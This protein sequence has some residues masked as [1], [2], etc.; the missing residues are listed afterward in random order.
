VAAGVAAASV[1]GLAAAAYADALPPALQSIAHAVIGA[2]PAHSGHP[3]GQNSARTSGGSGPAGVAGQA[4][5]VPSTAPSAT[6]SPRP[7]GPSTVAVSPRSGLCTAWREG[8]VAADSVAYQALVKAAGSAE[9][10]PGYCGAPMPHPTGPP[11]AAGSS[12]GSA[13]P[14]QPAHPDW[15]PSPQPTS[16]ARQ[17]GAVGSRPAH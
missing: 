17:A 14:A 8:G 3:P 1:T 13:A 4:G 12:A 9:A 5:G 16:S 2:P 10:I 7:V 15:A 6:P 11:P